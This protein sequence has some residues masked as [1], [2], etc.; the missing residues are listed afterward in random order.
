MG[1]LPTNSPEKIDTDL[2]QDMANA[3]APSMDQYLDK[4]NLAK[5]VRQEVAG[6]EKNNQSE[7]V[8]GDLFE[9]ED[10]EDLDNEAELHKAEAERYMDIEQDRVQDSDLAHEMANA[11]VPSMDSALEHEASAKEIQAET[12]EAREEMAAQDPYPDGS[13]NDEWV[14]DVEAQQHR[15]MADS[16]R[17]EADRQAEEVQEAREAVDQAS[18]DQE[19]SIH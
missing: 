17:R 4:K 2:D 8:A 18:Q 16:E 19:L 3:A 15:D 6:Y 1:E 9:G 11:A 7:Y 13:L 5:E 12:D 14:G 10:A